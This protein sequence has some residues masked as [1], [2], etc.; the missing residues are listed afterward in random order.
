M[1]IYAM[2]DLQGCLAPFHQL[3]DSIKFDPEADQLWLAGDIVNRGPASLAT[4][5]FVKGLGSSV[6]A[7]LGNHDLHLLTVAAGLRPQ[8]ERDTFEDILSAPDRD[9]LLFWLRHLPFVQKDDSLKVIMV[10]AG[11]YPHW[12]HKKLI[13][14]SRE[15]ED[16]LKGDSHVDLLSNLYPA[17]PLKWHKSLTGW[18]RY[19]FIA[20]ALTRL[21]CLSTDDALDF[22]Y[23]GP[24]E[25][26]PKGLTPWFQHPGRKCKNW[27]LIFGHWAALGHFMDNN[28]ISLDSGCVWGKRLTAVRIDSAHNQIWQVECE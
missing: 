20:N 18:E 1:A 2:G 14:Y 13:R 3:L 23:K 12:G 8:K 22:A 7:V 27:R 4:L 25:S 17:P 6:K 10:H 28:L 5:R 9:E 15:V 26:R 21:R 11:I 16:I 24:P 19:R